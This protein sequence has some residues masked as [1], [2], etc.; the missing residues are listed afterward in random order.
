MV[1]L[2]YFSPLLH[3]KCVYCGFRARSSARFPARATTKPFLSCV[4][5]ERFYGQ[6]ASSET[7][8]V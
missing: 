1:G 7:N 5:R 2:G 6:F 4:Q 3:L 8:G